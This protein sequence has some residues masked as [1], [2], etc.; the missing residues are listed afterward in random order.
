MGNLLILPLDGKEN[1][2][3][4]MPRRRNLAGMAAATGLPEGHLATRRKSGETCC[5]M[6]ERGMQA[7][8]SVGL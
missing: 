8:G 2:S 3:A 1:V 5:L 4:T 7:A 6:W